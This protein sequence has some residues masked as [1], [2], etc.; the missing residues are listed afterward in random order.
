MTTQ[1]AM[2]F[3]QVELVLRGGRLVF[4]ESQ[5]WTPCAIGGLAQK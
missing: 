4:D 2:A 3:Q 1:N 5:K